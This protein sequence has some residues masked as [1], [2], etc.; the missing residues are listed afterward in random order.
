MIDSTL[1]GLKTNFFW[2]GAAK[3]SRFIFSC[4]AFNTGRHRSF[5]M[6]TTGKSSVYTKLSF[7]DSALK[8]PIW[9]VVTPFTGTSLAPQLT[10]LKA[11][12]PLV[13]NHMPKSSH[14]PIY[15][16]GEGT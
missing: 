1:L 16:V 2:V 14:Y 3:S 8:V 11:G 4:A 5:R 7:I 9:R 6:E 12:I 15:L 13:V 10:L